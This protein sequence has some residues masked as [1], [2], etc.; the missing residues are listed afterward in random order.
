MLRAPSVRLH[1]ALPLPPEPKRLAERELN[2][3]FLQRSVPSSGSAYL[4]RV[5]TS[6]RRVSL[7]KC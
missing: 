6:R 1:F 4:T 2:F 3:Q 7:Q 5:P